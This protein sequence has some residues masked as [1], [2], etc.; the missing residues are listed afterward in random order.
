MALARKADSPL[1]TLVKP[2]QPTVE[3]LTQ[4][5][6]SLQ[7]ALR[8]TLTLLAYAGVPGTHLVQIPDDI[9]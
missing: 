9:P 7:V 4:Q 6:Q 8:D 1:L 3:E 2:R 5:V